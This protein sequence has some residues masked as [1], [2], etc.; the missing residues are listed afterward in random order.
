MQTTINSQ[1]KSKKIK[2]IIYG[3]TCVTS[4]CLVVVGCHQCYRLGYNKGYDQ[5]KNRILDT[6]VDM[7]IKNGLTMVNSNNEEYLFTAKLIEQK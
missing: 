1:E 3:A 2:M 6:I 7:T 5:G 4:V